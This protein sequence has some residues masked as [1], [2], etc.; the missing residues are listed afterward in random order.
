MIILKA[1]NKDG[2]KFK[3]KADNLQGIIEKLNQI[4]ELSITEATQQ[5]IQKQLLKNNF[6]NIKW[7]Y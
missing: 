2:I 5:A 7:I 4:K 3:F 1:T 6:K